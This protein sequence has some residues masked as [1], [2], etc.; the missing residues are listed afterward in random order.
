MI[1]SSLVVVALLGWSNVAGAQPASEPP[2]P[3]PE[4]SPAPTPAVAPMPEPV[5]A[6]APT[7]APDAGHR[8]TLMW[9]PIRLVVPLVELT[10]EYRVKDKLGVSLTVGFGNRTVESSS[11]EEASGTEIEG[12]AQVRYYAIGDFNHGMEVGVEGLYEYVKF[13]EPLPATILAVAAG[14]FT[15]G[16]FLGYKIATGVGFTFEA[17]FGARYLAIEPTTQGTGT[18]VITESKWLPL[19]H[20]NIGWSF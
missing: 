8:I 3:Q 12:G 1:R 5:P 4:P 10:G 14:G 2:E 11:G 16:P 7:P 19:L 18:A 9:A 20:L 15:V 13:D 6:P 17:Q